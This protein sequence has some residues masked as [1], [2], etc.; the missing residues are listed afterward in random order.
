MLNF[1]TLFDINFIYQGLVM[2]KSLKENCKGNFTLYIFAFCEKSYKILTKL[3]LENTK[4]ISTTEL[5]SKIPSL[6]K[7]KPTRT[8]GEYCWTC[9]SAIILYCLNV[10]K[11]Q[12]CTYVDADLQFLSNPKA[13]L[14]EM[15]EKDSIL[16]TE[17]RYTP[18]YDQ[19][20]TSGK[21]CVQFMTFKNNQDGLKALKWW[22]NACI[23]W[24]YNKIEDGKF[25]DQKYLDDWTDKFEGVC[26]LE[27]LGG[28]VAP[29]NVQQY[30]IYQS[31]GQIYVK[32]DKQNVPIVFYHFHDIKIKDNKIF[33]GLSYYKSKIVEKLIY[34][35]YIKKLIEA[36]V[37]LNKIDDDIEVIRLNKEPFYKYLKTMPSKILRVK[38]G[39]N[40]YVKIFGKKVV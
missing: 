12:Q 27:H 25:G 7:A 30:E 33:K 40:G 28:G 18:I 38:I 20:E 3:N 17:H 36:S 24:C 34:K 39:R 2:Y 22:V 9:E 15:G 4:I 19:T 32:N 31:D 29:W 16:L 8:S 1:C 6:L 13:L 11:L 35:V 14:D 23:E 26:V 21:Y 5:E 10:F 37:F